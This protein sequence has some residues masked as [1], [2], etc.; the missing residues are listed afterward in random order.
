[1]LCSK[2]L[3]PTVYKGHCPYQREESG[4][5][6]LARGRDQKQTSQ[7]SLHQQNSSMCRGSWKRPPDFHHSQTIRRLVKGSLDTPHCKDYEL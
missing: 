2:N 4:P 6:C 7:L 1:M 5:F 3:R